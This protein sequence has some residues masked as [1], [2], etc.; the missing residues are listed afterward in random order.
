MISCCVD[1]FCL[2]LLRLD[3]IFPVPEEAEPEEESIF[4]EAQSWFEGE[5]SSHQ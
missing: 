2:Y 4:D 3:V 1:I 5:L